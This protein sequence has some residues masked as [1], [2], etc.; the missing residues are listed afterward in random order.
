MASTERHDKFE[1]AAIR[2]M[3]FNLEQK[4]LQNNLD[5][6]KQIDFDFNHKPKKKEKYVSIIDPKYLFKPR[7]FITP[8]ALSHRINAVGIKVEDIF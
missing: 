1:K 4:H 6:I 5:E 3:E 8:I 7:R 2:Q